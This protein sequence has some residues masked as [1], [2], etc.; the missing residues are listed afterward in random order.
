VFKKALEKSKKDNIIQTRLKNIIEKLT[1][2]VYDYTCLGIFEKHKLM[3]SF[4]MTTMIMEYEG[5]LIK[6][7]LDFFLKGNTSLEDVSNPKPF[8]WLNEIGWKDLDKLVDLGEE[9]L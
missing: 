7:E 8:V 4:Q 3:Y 9:Y 6:A 1:T 5:S 2:L